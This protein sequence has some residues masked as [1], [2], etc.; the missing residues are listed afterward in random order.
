MNLIVGLGNPGGEYARTK[1]N[2]G[3]MAADQILSRLKAS[4][5]NKSAFNGELF[6]A[7]DTLIL[8]PQT[9]MN[10]SGVSVSAVSNFYKPEK[11]IV[12]HDDLDLPFGALRFKFGGGNGGH[13]GLKSIDHHCSPNYLRVRMG[14]SRPA[15]KD[16]V[17]AYVL[18]PFLAAQVSSLDEWVAAAATAA[19]TL[20]EL[21]LETVAAKY[22]LKSADVEKSASAEKSSDA[23]KSASVEKSPDARKSP[24]EI[25]K[26]ADVR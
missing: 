20:C 26:P 17:L 23:G 25:E 2:A 21:P 9:Y 18:Q 11:L 16:E 10:N 4:K 3:F 8:K 22:T 12:I 14:I 6:R 1:H 13:N 19:L 7:G 24:A 15:S 5:V